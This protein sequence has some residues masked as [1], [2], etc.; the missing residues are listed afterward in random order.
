MNLLQSDLVSI[1]RTENHLRAAPSVVVRTK[2]VR[3]C[4]QFFW[5]GVFTSSGPMIKIKFAVAAFK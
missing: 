4:N 1:G 3:L 5:S 2:D